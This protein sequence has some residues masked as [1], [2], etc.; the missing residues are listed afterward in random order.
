[1]THSTSADAYYDPDRLELPSGLL[2][3]GRLVPGEGSAYAVN[4]PSDGRMAREERGASPAQVEQAVQ[5]AR[6]SFKASGWANGHP[7][8]RGRVLRLWAE[9]VERDAET[10]ARLESVVSPFL[11]TATRDRVVG[12]VAELIRWNAELAD[13]INGEMLSSADDVWSMVVREPYGV[14]V[15]I[16]PWNAPLFLAALKLAP[17]L[18]AGNAIVLKPAEGTPYSVIRLAQLAIEAGVPAGLI[19]VLPGLGAEAGSA[20]VRNAGVDYVS[21]TGSTASGARIMSDAALHGLKPVSLELGGKSP[22]LVLAD[23][24]NLDRVA[25]TLVTSVC[26][27]AGQICFCS[28][29]LV[30]DERIADDLL[31]RVQKRLGRV[32]AGPTWSASTSLSPIYSEGQARRIEDILARAGEGGAELL[33]GGRRQDTGHGGVYFEPTL[34]NAPRADN[35]AVREEI[36]GPVLTVQI[37]RDLEEGLQLADHPIYGL[38]GAVHT[39]DLNKALRAARAIQAGTVWVNHYGP[40]GDLNNP[41]APHKQS[42]MGHDGGVGALTKYLKTKNVRVLVS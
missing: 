42:G 10:L 30:V 13:K 24:G 41:N 14:V 25:D 32:V 31:A 16:S 36:F 22:Q 17:A 4:R 39:T 29:R 18:A 40:T 7:R 11:F 38:A 1:M 19:Q 37:F 33:Q 28:T 21:F 2:I 26:G 20:L 3:D 9:L 12:G 8:Q 6:R 23:A 27:N 5:I 35:P 34:V 15:G